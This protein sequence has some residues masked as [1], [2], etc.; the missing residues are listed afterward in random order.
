[1]R[2]LTKD[3]LKCYNPREK[4]NKGLNHK[5]QKKM[6]VL[7][8]DSEIQTDTCEVPIPGSLVRMS[9]L[10]VKPE[11]SPVLR[12]CAALYEPA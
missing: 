1:M 3:N 6:Y 4:P 5:R 7:I 2:T 12:M 8:S 11:E 9:F 10:S